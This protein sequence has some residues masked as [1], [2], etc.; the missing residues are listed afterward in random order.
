VPVP[1]PLPLPEKV[2][3]SCE[4]KLLCNGAKARAWAGAWVVSFDNPKV[5][6]ELIIASKN[7]HKIREFREMFKNLK[8]FD[9]TSLLNFPNY[10]LPPETGAT[11]KEN[12]LIKARDVAKKLNK[13]AL[14]DDSGLV[15]SRLN[16][17][18][19]VH[20]Q[21]YA[22]ENATDQDNCRKLL[23]QMQNLHGIERSAYFECCLALCGPDGYEK[24]ISG[25]CEGYIISE[26]RGRNGFGYDPLFV[27]HDYDKTF[28]EMDES[29]KNRISHRYKAFEK[30]LVL[31]ESLKIKQSN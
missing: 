4:Y 2:L 10:V 29:T 30:M 13:W 31:L 11:F 21:R 8:Q 26:E 17:E 27:K 18:P 1:L 9:I 5:L 25:L 7:V 12:A 19:G 20:S 24:T 3:K 15:V 23:S 22:G 6:M 14:A 28:A 16:G